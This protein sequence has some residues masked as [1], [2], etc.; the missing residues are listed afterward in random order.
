MERLLSAS[1]LLHGQACDHCALLAVLCPSC[2]AV[3]GEC[4]M[5]QAIAGLT[6]GQLEEAPMATDSTPGPLP[7]G[8]AVLWSDGDATV[9]LGKAAR[10][11][12]DAVVIVDAHLDT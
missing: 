11:L 9:R 2:R 6:A 10:S 5:H 8:E 3:I 12:L 1:L 7:P 4:P